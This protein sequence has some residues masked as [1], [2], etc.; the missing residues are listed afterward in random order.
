LAAYLFVKVKENSPDFTKPS[1]T[2]HCV[3]SLHALLDQITDKPFPP[4]NTAFWQPT[5]LGGK[6]CTDWTRIALHHVNTTSVNRTCPT[7]FENKLKNK[8]YELQLGKW[9]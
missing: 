8:F 5:K 3:W 9:P 1:D 4:E 2:Q 7:I 6:S